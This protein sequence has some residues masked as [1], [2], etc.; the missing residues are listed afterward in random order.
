MV[1]VCKFTGPKYS[2]LCKAS[3]PPFS[4]N[5]LPGTPSMA[6]VIPSGVVFAQSVLFTATFAKKLL[7]SYDKIALRVDV[8]SDIALMV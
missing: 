4:T 2:L 5:N 6:C 3:G 1:N 7:E 8:C